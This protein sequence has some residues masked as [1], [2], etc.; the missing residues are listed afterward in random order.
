[1]NLGSKHT[2]TFY[3]ALAFQNVLNN[4]TESKTGG[5]MPNLMSEVKI[6]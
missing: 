5:A 6:N 4:F 2:L 1:M 3:I